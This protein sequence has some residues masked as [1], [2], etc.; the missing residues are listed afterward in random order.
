MK[1]L[2]IEA[3]NIIGLKRAEIICG[4]PITLIA[5]DNE[6]GKSS[7]ADAISMAF[8]GEP[9]RVKLKKDIKQLMH[10]DAKKGG[11][12]LIGA[13]DEVLA[14]F[15]LPAGK[16]E[17]GDSMEAQVGF[18]FLPLVLDPQ[19]F[20]KME[21]KER[22]ATLFKLTGCS[23]KPDYILGEL[24]AAGCDMKL[25]EMLIG[26]ARSGF[27]VMAEEAKKRAADAR[28]VWQHTTG[29]TWGSEKAEGW[30]VDIPA[31]KDVTQE[32][33]AAALAEQQKIADEIEKGIAYR[34]RLDSDIEHAAGYA[35]KEEDLRSKA[36][37]LKRAN[38]KLE[39]TTS[40]LEKQ[41]ARRNT[42]N[43]QLG[44][45]PACACPH[46]GE[47]VLIVNGELQD[48][49]GSPT[50]EQRA[51]AKK[52]L[53]AVVESIG[54]LERTKANDTKA[55]REAE[56]AGQQ[57]AAH[58][59]EKKE[60]PAAGLM[61]RTE[62]ALTQQRQAFS[63]A[64]ARHSALRE[65]FDLIAGAEKTNAVASE[66]H[67]EIKAWKAIET[68]LLPTGI[69]SRLL[70]KAISPVN[71]ALEVMARIT[72]WSLPKIELD[73]SLTYGGRPYALSSES[74]QWRFDAMIALVVAQM[75]TLKFVMLDRIDVLSNRHRVCLVQLLDSIVNAG[76]ID[77][78]V[79]LGTMKSAPDMSSAS[80]HFQSLWIEKGVVLSKGLE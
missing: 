49:N 26:M 30:E 19:S 14:S 60:A 31:G 64:Q 52:E 53:A 40:D 44:T 41:L 65:R 48:G 32:D 9:R 21:E 51:E 55:V 66:K 23:A 61:E 12:R 16:H 72:G 62:E 15:T 63:T 73:M 58:I 38:A 43:A 45:A 5:G 71:T 78:A 27:P 11:I 2:K 59:A 57:L 20:A 69:P 33:I 8:R 6:A 70:E 25:A 35:E 79:I 39:A 67:N 50:A 28:A 47:A 10:N 42:L 68:E 37:L 13:D 18:E 56:L 4:Q 36:G 22:R 74:A 29:E 76:N 24:K 17:L 80:P 46:C 75:S 3:Q 54:M 77:G 34:A 7:L 1:I